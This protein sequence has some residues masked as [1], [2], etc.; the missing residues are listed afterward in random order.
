MST[1]KSMEST[2]IEIALPWIT[3]GAVEW[4]KE[5]DLKVLALHGWMDN[6]ASFNALA[7]LLPEMNLIAVDLPGHGK[8][9][10]IPQG[11]GLHFIDFI[12]LVLEVAD[13]LGWDH[14]ILMGHSMGAA[15]GCLVAG[16]DPDRIQKL[17]LLE[18]IGPLS[19][20]PEE[21]PERLLKAIMT[22]QKILN[23]NQ[24]HFPTVEAAVSARK[25]GSD[26][27]LGSAVE[28]VS[29]TLVREHKGY[30]FTHDPRL[31][32]ESRMRL[33]EE[34]IM[35]FMK[36][37]RCPALFVKAL[38]GWPFPEDLVAERIKCVENL[39]VEE[40]EGGHHVHMIHPEPVAERITDFL[41]NC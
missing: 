24:R 7:P 25:S 27:D 4:G 38:S 14:F 10:H 6:A 40:I 28:L 36:R 33:S 35:A 41:L 2:E 15:I 8:S 30:R 29:R 26:L 21:T 22:E 37:I 34:M 39:R 19:Q 12:P 5:H 13:V 16:C 1:T 17:I 23:R 31:R 32:A 9:G 11:V 18:G 20:T 3:L